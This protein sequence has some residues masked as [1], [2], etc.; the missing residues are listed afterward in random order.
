MTDPKATKRIHDYWTKKG[1]PGYAK[2]GWGTRGDFT[3]AKRLI[4]EKIAKNSPEKMKYLNQIIAQWHH[5]ALGY[6]PGDL[7]MPGNKTTAEARA[8]RASLT[9]EASG[10][11]GVDYSEVTRLMVEH[12]VEGIEPVDHTDDTDE[13]E[14]AQS[15]WEAVLVSSVSGNQVRPPLSYFHRHESGE[16]TVIEEPD[17][18]GFRRTYGYAA[19]WGVC[20]IGFD[21]R[22]VEPPI[23]GSDDYPEFH[24]GRTKVTDRTV[25]ATSPPAC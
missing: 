13:T 6:W 5:D 10:E 3:R 21:G 4:G 8:E 18:N 25:T 24:L 12:E 19:E 23:A 9:V 20:H 17:E 2:I 14:Q 16:A 22:C 7:D 11:Q 1:Q 15:V